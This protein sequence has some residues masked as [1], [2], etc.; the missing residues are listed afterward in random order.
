[1]DLEKKI[2]EI[3]RKAMMEQV[4]EDIHAW[5]IERKIIR[6]EIPMPQFPPLRS[7]FVFRR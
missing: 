7:P 2:D 6:G 4:V 1:M 3:C 5:E